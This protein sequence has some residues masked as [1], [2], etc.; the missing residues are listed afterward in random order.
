M[1]LDFFLSFF[2]FNC[3]WRHS[4]ILLPRLE[5]SG[6]TIL[7]HCNLCLSGSSDPP[8]SA[9]RVAGITGVCRHAWLSFVFLVEMGFH[10]V[11]QDGLD[12]LAS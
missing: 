8:S 10:H 12:V 7:A 3:F 5:Y 6:G 11:G 2:F 4:L 1:F 9:S